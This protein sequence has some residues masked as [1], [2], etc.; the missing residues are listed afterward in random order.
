M[1]LPLGQPGTQAH[2]H[3][4]ANFFIIARRL[5][6]YSYRTAGQ[7]RRILPNTRQHTT[8]ETGHVRFN[9][10]LFGCCLTAPLSLE[11]GA[12]PEN[13]HVLCCQIKSTFLL[14]FCVLGEIV[15]P[16]E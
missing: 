1:A 5:V 13:S 3:A 9:F 10:S 15:L 14:T 4:L 11:K 7:N 2:A 8:A 16:C 6:E 12:Y